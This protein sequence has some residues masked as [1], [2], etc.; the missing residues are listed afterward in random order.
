VL[1]KFYSEKIYAFTQYFLEQAA[2]ELEM[3]LEELRLY[4]ERVKREDGVDAI[5]IGCLKD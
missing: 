4:Y 1:P 3:E 5:P 2:G